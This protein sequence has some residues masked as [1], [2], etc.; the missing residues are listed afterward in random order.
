MKETNSPAPLS[1]PERGLIADS[2]QGGPSFTPCSL[3]GYSASYPSPWGSETGQR[4]PLCNQRREP[5]TGYGES[6][7]RGFGD[8]AQGHAAPALP[9]AFRWRQRRRFRSPSDGVSVARGLGGQSAPEAG[10]ARAAPRERQG[11]LP[12]EAPGWQRLQTTNDPAESGAGDSR[13][14]GLSTC[15]EPASMQPARAWAAAS[16]ACAV[17]AAP[18]ARAP[19]R[20][21]RGLLGLPSSEAD[22]L[23]GFPAGTAPAPQLS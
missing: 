14:G 11:R 7:R 1:Q 4:D 18:P 21:G 8:R 3:A 13:R 9:V 16:R 22:A 17:S 12:A 5:R 19:G 20:F 15:P 10:R 6:A 23:P 2:L